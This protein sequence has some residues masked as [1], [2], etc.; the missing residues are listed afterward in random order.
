MTLVMGYGANTPTNP[1]ERT[2]AVLMMMVR[3]VRSMSTCIYFLSQSQVCGG[4][5]A[6]I[7]GGVCEVSCKLS[8]T[9]C[10]IHQRLVNSICFRSCPLQTPL[11]HTLGTAWIY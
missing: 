11:P 6:Y 5:Y 9:L 10:Y 1:G 3:V 7:I 8:R 4:T 2:V